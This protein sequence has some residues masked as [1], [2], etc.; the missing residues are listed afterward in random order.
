MSRMER[1]PEGRD[2]IH[3]N[4]PKFLPVRA[5]LSQWAG[6]FQR[7]ENCELPRE[8]VGREGADNWRALIEIGSTLGYPATARAVALAM[9][10]PI[11]DPVTLLLWDIRRIRELPAPA[12]YTAD[13]LGPPACGPRI[14]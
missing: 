3:P 12:G 1:H 8:L 2:E 6:G 10:R 9:H 13:E 5:L 11:K 4:D 7:P 14:C